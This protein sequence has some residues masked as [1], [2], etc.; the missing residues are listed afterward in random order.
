VVTTRAEAT[1]RR[2]AERMVAGVGLVELDG[3]LRNE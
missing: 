2:T 3:L 1:E